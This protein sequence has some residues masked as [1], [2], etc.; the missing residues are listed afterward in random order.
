MLRSQGKGKR[1]RHSFLGM[2]VAWA[3]W[4]L[5]VGCSAGW[6]DFE[7]YVFGISL[8]VCLL[9]WLLVGLPVYWFWPRVGILWHPLTFFLTGGIAGAIVWTLL[10]G[11]L[12]AW[13]PGGIGAISAGTAWWL[14]ERGLRRQFGAE[15]SESS[16]P[17]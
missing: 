10:G 3:I 2:V 14:E 12:P 17:S 9:S 11:F 1:V 4:C 7:I 13:I 6:N 8:I 5:A 15:S 16:T